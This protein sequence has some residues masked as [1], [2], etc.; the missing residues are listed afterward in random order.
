MNLIDTPLVAAPFKG[1]GTKYFDDFY[2]MFPRGKTSA[3]GEDVCIV[4][5]T[6]KSG[7]FDRFNV[8][9]TNAVM[10]VGNDRHP[11]AWATHEEPG[12]GFSRRHGIG[13]TVSV[14]RVIC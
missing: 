3:N 4:M 11:D 2:R 6:G 13:Y 5:F 1:C 14:I 10:F 8:A 9:C 12:G 7:G